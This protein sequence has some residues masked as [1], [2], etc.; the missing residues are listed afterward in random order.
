MASPSRPRP[1][2][3]LLQPTEHYDVPT[4]KLCA[5][6]STVD[7]SDFYVRRRGGEGAQGE[8]EGGR[9]GKAG[10]EGGRSGSNGFDWKDK[11]KDKKTG[12][13]PLVVRYLPLDLWF[14][15][16]VLKDSTIDEIRFHLL[17]LSGLIPPQPYRHDL[18]PSFDSLPK[19]PA[20]S[21]FELLSRNPPKGSVLVSES[22]GEGGS[23]RKS[24]SLAGNGRPKN[25]EVAGLGGGKGKEKEKE[26]ESGWN[27]FQH[28]IKPSISSSNLRSTFSSSSSSAAHNNSLASTPTSS[29]T[30]A[31]VPHPPP[32]CS[33]AHPALPSPLHPHPSSSSISLP[34][35]PTAIPSNSTSTN[36]APSSSATTT[37]SLLSDLS[38]ACSSD[39]GEAAAGDQSWSLVGY[40]SP[41]QTSHPRSRTDSQAA[42]VLSLALS[43]VES[44]PSSSSLPLKVKF[45]PA[46]APPGIVVEKSISPSFEGGSFAGGGGTGKGTTT[47][48]SSSS[49]T[50]KGKV[51]L[52]AA[53]ATRSYH[54]DHETERVLKGY[55]LVCF[56]TVSRN[57]NEGGRG[58]EGKL[59]RLV[60]V[61][62]GLDGKI[63]FPA[64]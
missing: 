17:S 64:G 34:S 38:L 16:S 21:V 62:F 54:L 7:E 6:P 36:P 51:V 27:K 11:E 52:S 61:W 2:P 30:P 5:P 12:L 20:K 29:S 1:R 41:P 14:C 13:L 10:V 46:P 63:G 31:L 28:I 58:R 45:A 53:A 22:F 40:P 56:G 59:T 18:V 47:A 49:T 32:P 57:T 35:S 23:S 3:P 15:T 8:E 60:S 48:T 55:D 33:Y 24:A 43:T 50:R 37:S 9:G 42:S 4:G 39:G 44:S 26:K 19:I 25:S